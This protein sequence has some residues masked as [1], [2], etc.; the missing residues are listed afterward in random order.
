[1]GLLGALKGVVI[2]A[3]EVAHGMRLAKDTQAALALMRGMPQDVGG[4]AF[5]LFLGL[6]S[7][8]MDNWR[9]WSSDGRLRAA[10]AFHDEGRSHKDFNIGIACGHYLAAAWLESSMRQSEQARATFNEL[11]KLTMDFVAHMSPVSG[12]PSSTRSSSPSL[13]APSEAQ[14]AGPVPD[15][16]GSATWPTPKPGGQGSTAHGRSLHAGAAKSNPEA[17]PRAHVAEL[18]STCLRE[19]LISASL[20]RHV[21]SIKQIAGLLED[22]SV[23]A[24]NRGPEVQN[25]INAT[26]FGI[27]KPLCWEVHLRNDPDTP[28]ML[29]FFVNELGH[30]DW[31]A[32]SICEILQ[33]QASDPAQPLFRTIARAEAASERFYRDRDARPFK[34]IG[35]MLLR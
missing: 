4:Q 33:Q 25:L 7:H 15:N 23:L 2:D 18:A 1:M 27:L 34:V 11:E 5:L 10:R 14:R 6:R 29:E 8:T 20:G 17:N 32:S 24:G 3:T 28:A 16:S 30:S 21:G 22:E 35:E 13:P 12:L 19:V 26:A 9:T 31:A